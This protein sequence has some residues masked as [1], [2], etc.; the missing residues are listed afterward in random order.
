MPLHDHE[1]TPRARSFARRTRPLPAVVPG[2]QT[3]RNPKC[4]SPSK[5]ESLQ[6][7]MLVVG[8]VDANAWQGRECQLDLQATRHTC[9]SR[10]AIKS[11]KA[12]ILSFGCTL[13]KECDRPAVGCVP[14]RLMSHSPL[15]PLTLLPDSCVAGHCPGR[16]PCHRPSSHLVTLGPRPH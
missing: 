12:G 3:A 6:D 11:S 5:L 14:G 1:A 9:Q 15:A 16:H 2:P 8:F 4:M 13:R 7:Q 10:K